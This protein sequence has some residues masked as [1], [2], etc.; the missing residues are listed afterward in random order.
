[1]DSE[2]CGQGRVLSHERVHIEL[3]YAIWV[4][5]KGGPKQGVVSHW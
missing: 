4:K 5:K 1:M 3:A 2:S